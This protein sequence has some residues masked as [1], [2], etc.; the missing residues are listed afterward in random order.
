MKY[1]TCIVGEH[2]MLNKDT[3][4]DKA[5]ALSGQDRG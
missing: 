3:D 2:K 4:N 1:G 5:H